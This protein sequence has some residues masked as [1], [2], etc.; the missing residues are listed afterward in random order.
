[1]AIL[2]VAETKLPTIQIIMPD[3][4]LFCLIIFSIPF[5]RSSPGFYLEIIIALIVFFFYLYLLFIIF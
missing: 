4:I 5:L 3:L 2:N 1:L